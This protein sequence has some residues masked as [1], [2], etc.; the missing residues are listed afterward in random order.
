MARFCKNCGT[1]L[2]D[3]ATVCGKCGAPVGAAPGGSPVHPAPSAIGSDKLKLGVLIAS[4]VVILSTFL[5][6]AT[7]SLFGFSES[8]SLLEGGDG[9]F[10]IAAS[11]VAIVGVLINKPILPL[12][13]GVITALISLFEIVDMKTQLGDY[14]SMVDMSMGFYLSLVGSIALAVLGVLVFLNAKKGQ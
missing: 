14:S 1:P 12:V 4:A 3:G 9:W 5:P 6:Y 2:N 8:V 13:G 7:V 10:F 11:A